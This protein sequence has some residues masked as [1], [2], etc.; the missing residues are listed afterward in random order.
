[1]IPFITGTAMK[2]LHD[3]LKEL[4]DV[5]QKTA[6]EIKKNVLVPSSTKKLVDG[7]AAGAD[8]MMVFCNSNSLSPDYS[9]SLGSPTRK[10]GRRNELPS[11]TRRA[12]KAHC[13]LETEDR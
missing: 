1:M 6:K 11:L 13:A 4:K 9:P 8:L 12:S 7:I 3:D 10:R 2:K 5:A